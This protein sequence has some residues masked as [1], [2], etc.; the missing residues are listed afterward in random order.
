M[1]S[2]DSAAGPRPRIAVDIGSTLIKIAR[3][4]GDGE[5]QEQTLHGRDFDAG[6]ARQVESLLDSLGAIRDDDVLVC[7]SA[8]GGLRVGVVCLTPL[9]S[10]A[11]LRNQVLLAGGKTLCSYTASTRSL[12]RCPRW[13]SFW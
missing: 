5:L 6:I 12:P 7:S 3:V 13:I 2:A 11:T 1:G 4:R 9:Y 8:N 10:G